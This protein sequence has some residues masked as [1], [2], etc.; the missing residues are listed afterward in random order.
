M[1]RVVL[2]LTPTHSVA[3]ES[4][5][6]ESSKLPK[7]IDF[8][9]KE[10][11]PLPFDIPDKISLWKEFLQ[12]FEKQSSC[13]TGTTFPPFEKILS[14]LPG[15]YFACRDNAQWLKVCELCELWIVGCGSWI[16]APEKHIEPLDMKAAPRVGL[17]SAC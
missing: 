1:Q 9:S 13:L 2:Q 12:C 15:A 4:Q 8:E 3:G 7:N 17:F 6:V 11:P 14:T 10:N 5:L 16:V